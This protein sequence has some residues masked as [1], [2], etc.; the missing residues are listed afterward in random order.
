M[1]IDDIEISIQKEQLP[2]NS[3]RKQPPKKEEERPNR[4]A[5]EEVSGKKKRL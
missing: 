2:K 4:I 3:L 1:E 5:S